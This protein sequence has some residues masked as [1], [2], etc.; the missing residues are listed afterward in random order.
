M[1]GIKPLK[2]TLL[3][4]ITQ[5]QCLTCYHIQHLYS[6]QLIVA[7]HYG[8]PSTVKQFKD[9]LSLPHG[10]DFASSAVSADSVAASDMGG[11]MSGQSTAIWNAM[12]LA[13]GVCLAMTTGCCSVTHVM[14]QQMALSRMSLPSV[15]T[16][17]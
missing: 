15:T 5:L 7:S 11:C 2:K 4:Q 13:V 17:L 16:L 9:V 1:Y 12:Q 10:H 3:S 8:N 14:Q 6:V